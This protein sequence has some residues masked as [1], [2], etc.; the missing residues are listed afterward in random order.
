VNKHNNN[1][2]KNSNNNNNVNKK[3]K[4]QHAK[5]QYMLKTHLKSSP[6]LSNNYLNQI[7]SIRTNH[8]LQVLLVPNWL[9]QE[10]LLGIKK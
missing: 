7:I 10:V 2:N 6:F 4:I 9:H 1:H 8:C 5:Y 3:K